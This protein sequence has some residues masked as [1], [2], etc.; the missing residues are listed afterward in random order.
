MHNLHVTHVFHHMQVYTCPMALY[1]VDGTY[2]APKLLDV[3]QDPVD[4]AVSASQE[5]NSSMEE[6][7]IT[8]RDCNIVSTPSYDVLY[9]FARHSGFSVLVNYKVNGVPEIV[10]QSSYVQSTHARIQN[11]QQ[12]SAAF[13]KA[14]SSVSPLPSTKSI[15]SSATHA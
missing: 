4:T 2:G 14:V 6:S 5:V 11:T 15:R 8:T 13:R 9:T 10:Q 1:A 12:R 3:S 7:A